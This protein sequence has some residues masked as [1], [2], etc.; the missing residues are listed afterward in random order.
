MAADGPVS[1]CGICLPQALSRAF[2]QANEP[3]SAIAQHEAYIGTPYAFRSVANLDGIS[4]APSHER[5]GQLYESK[6]NTAKAIEHYAKFIEMW[7]NADP[8]LQPRVA[9]ARERLKKLTPVERP[10]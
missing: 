4:L 2:D 10:R 8:E 6:G 5:L 9:A 1:S 7:K 3:D